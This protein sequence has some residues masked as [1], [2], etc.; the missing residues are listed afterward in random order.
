MI[1]LI[2]IKI[3]HL[4][5]KEC[6]LYSFSLQTYLYM[7]KNCKNDQCSSACGSKRMDTAYVSIRRLVKQITVKANNGISAVKSKRQLCIYLHRLISKIRYDKESK[8][9]ECVY[10]AIYI[11]TEVRRHIHMLVHAYKISEQVS[12]KLTTVLVSEVK[13]GIR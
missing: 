12:K 5:T 3:T 4:L 11:K 8:G 2:K 7:Y 1:V 6:Y 9:Q 13:W 10:Y